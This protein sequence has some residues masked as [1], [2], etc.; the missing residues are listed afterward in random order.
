MIAEHP[1]RERSD[2][3][4]ARDRGPSRHPPQKKRAGQ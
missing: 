2:E 4:D 3:H 1:E